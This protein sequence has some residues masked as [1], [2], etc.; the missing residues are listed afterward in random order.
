MF[1]TSVILIDS[2]LGAYNQVRG[3]RLVMMRESQI[4]KIFNFRNLID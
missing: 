2:K 1:Y 3:S 4:S